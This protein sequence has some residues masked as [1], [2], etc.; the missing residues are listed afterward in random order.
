ML[1]S[2]RPPTWFQPEEAKPVDTLLDILLPAI[3]A[4]MRIEIEALASAA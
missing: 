2:I 4:K 3:A 1:R